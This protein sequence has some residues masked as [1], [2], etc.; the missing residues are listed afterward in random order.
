MCTDVLPVHVCLPCVLL[1]PGGQKTI[2]DP[3]E[4]QLLMVA[5]ATWMQRTDP[6]GSSEREPSDLDD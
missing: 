6:G 5:I 2:S 4:P 3:L 1:V